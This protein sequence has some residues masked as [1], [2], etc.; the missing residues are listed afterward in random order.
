MATTK[1]SNFKKAGDIKLANGGYLSDKKE[2]A[3]THAGFV[4]AQ[5]RAHL[6]CTL[7]D[8][9]KGKTFTTQEPEDFAALL[10]EVRIGINDTAVESH[11]KIPTATE[12]KLTK[13]LADEALA[14][15]K[16]GEAAEAATELNNFLQEFN[17]V[18]EFETFGL[19]FSRGVQKLE[20]IYTMKEII[21]AS[22]TVY[23]VLS[24]QG[25]SL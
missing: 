8:G 24:S 12:G 22:K 5:Q 9:M 7:A 18:S 3:I 21:S 13:Q 2:N 11:V 15:I 6:L 1:A 19:F 4:A 10:N 14:F 23:P 17:I 16:D 20:K 25:L